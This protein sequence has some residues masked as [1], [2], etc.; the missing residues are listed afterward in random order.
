M[1]ILA[2]H[3][4]DETLGCGG[5]IAAASRQGLRPRVAYLTDGSASHPGSSAWPR[6]RLAAARRGEALEALSA[7]GVPAGDVR[8]LDW[9]DAAPY[10]PGARRY[11]QTLAALI[12]WIGRRGVNSL[13]APWIGED[14]CDHVAAA[15]LALSLA[16]RIGA[17]VT[18]MSYLVWGWADPRLVRDARHGRVWTLRCPRTVS[19]RRTALACHRTQVTDIINDTEHAFRVPPELAALTE[20][21]VEIYLRAA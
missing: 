20:R 14:H 8:F 9:P 5:L 11:S 10:A 3:Q 16:G 19:Q 7:L 17:P 6:P 4:D 2:P 12:G 15:N 1:L 18:L 21:P 13:W